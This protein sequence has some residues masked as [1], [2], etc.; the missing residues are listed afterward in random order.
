MREQRRLDLVQHDLDRGRAL[1]GDAGEALGQA[2]AARRHVEPALQRGDD[3][4][5]IEVAAIMQLHALAQLD[6]VGLAV[7]RDGG[8]RGSQHR[9]G[10]P[11]GVEGEQR[12]VDML[13]DRAD[14]VGGRR[15]RVERLRLADHGEVRARRRLG[16]AGRR[17]QHGRGGETGR[18]AGKATSRQGC[19]RECVVVHNRSLDNR[20]CGAMKFYYP[21]D[22][23]PPAEWQAIES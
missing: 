22:I 1:G 10:R 17:S 6:R 4:L 16:L 2:L 5:G 20:Y 23:M 12:L 3:V 11:V 21:L 18:K 8:Q 19:A 9:L 15:H 7:G 14:E 13:H